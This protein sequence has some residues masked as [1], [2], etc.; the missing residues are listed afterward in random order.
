MISRIGRRSPVL[1]LRRTVANSS[2]LR[3]QPRRVMCFA[4]LAFHG[5][6]QTYG[7]VFLFVEAHL[8]EK[9]ALSSLVIFVLYFVMWIISKR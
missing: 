1:F 7:L 9:E 6:G 5:G 3:Q 4:T 2:S 8:R